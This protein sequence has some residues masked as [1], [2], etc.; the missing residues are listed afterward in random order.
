MAIPASLNARLLAAPAFEVDASL[1]I[2][3]RNLRHRLREGK[4][5]GLRFAKPQVELIWNLGLLVDAG[6]NALQAA[7]AEILIDITGLTVH[8]DLEIPH[9]AFHPGDLGKRP[10]G[11]V[12]MLL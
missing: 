6:L 12:L 8:R 10:Q 9:V 11:D 7:D 5:D 3:H 4:I 1:R 2:D